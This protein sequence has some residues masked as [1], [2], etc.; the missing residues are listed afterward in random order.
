MPAIAKRLPAVRVVAGS[1]SPYA[2]IFFL[3]PFLSF[4]GPRFSNQKRERKKTMQL[5]FRRRA[6]SNLCP[7]LYFEKDSRKLARSV[8]SYSLGLVAVQELFLAGPTLHAP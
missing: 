4:P 2:A 6:R 5:F 1:N 8:G 3:F 7:F